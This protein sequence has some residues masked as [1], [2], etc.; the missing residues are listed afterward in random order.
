MPACIMTRVRTFCTIMD[1]SKSGY[2]S[3]VVI[4]LACYLLLILAPLLV[5][6]IGHPEPSRGFWIEFGVGLG[7]V[8][9]AIMVL[10]FVLTA[11]VPGVATP[12]G[13]DAMLQFHR[14]AG[15][16][17][18]LFIL[19]H[20]LILLVSNPE[21]LSFFDP[22]I[23]APRA[24]ALVTVLIML[25]LLIVLTISRTWFRITYEWWRLSHGAMALGVAMI[26]LGHI[27]MVGFYISSFWKQAFMV[28]MTGAGI[29]L[30]L[31]SRVINPRLMLKQPYRTVEIHQEADRIWTLA[32]EPVGH[33]GLKFQPGQ[34]V[35]LTL[36]DQPY[37]LQQHPFSLASSAQRR[38]QY[39]LTIKAL[40]DFTES[41]RRVQ[42]GTSAWLEGPYGA[43]TPDQRPGIDAVMIAGGIGITPIIS[44]LRTLADRDDPRRLVLIYGAVR[45]DAMA[46]ISEIE[47]LKERL[48]LTF[49]P[50]LEHPPE[51]WHGETGRINE[52]IMDKYM[53]PVSETVEHFV[54]GPEPM[55]DLVESYLNQRGVP[56]R[57]L[58]SE[59][60]K[61]V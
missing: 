34:F 60:F 29:S 16:T 47:T 59:R 6:W 52:S 2:R 18:Y 28:L 25:T 49:I 30:L 14:Q 27:L 24:M 21:Y 9:M 3:Q 53:P 36:G 13:T 20:A 33:S 35:W 37:S 38:D 43:F 50:V 19:A 45:L 7:F 15:F 39:L 41:I 1:R 26:G 44:I 10:Q 5:A 8:G 54:C 17:A 32:L 57:K 22:R 55:M 42:P 31:F 48:N 23:N 4:W 12:F 56:I 58:H 61:I 11:R 51:D 46:F 40:G